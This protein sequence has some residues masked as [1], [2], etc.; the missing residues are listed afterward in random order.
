[1]ETMANELVEQIPSLPDQL[2]KDLITE[3]LTFLKE[4]VY[5]SRL[6]LKVNYEKMP[7]A[8]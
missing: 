8:I 1:M 4:Q 6:N 2:P 5:R 3:R 7:D